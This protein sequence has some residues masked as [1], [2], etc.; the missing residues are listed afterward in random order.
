MNFLI[1]GNLCFS[2]SWNSVLKREMEVGRVMEEILGSGVIK[3]KILKIFIIVM[4]IWFSDNG[5][6]M[7]NRIW[8]F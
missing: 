7:C 3:S 2:W 6:G 8:Y 1:L 4:L 5:I